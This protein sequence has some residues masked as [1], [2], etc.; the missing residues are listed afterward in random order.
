MLRENL[1]HRG[2]TLGV[3]RHEPYWQVN[4][5]ALLPS[6]VALPIGEDFARDFE[7]DAAIHKAKRRIDWFLE[8]QTLSQL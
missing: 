3:T 6:V 8:K 5:Y 1:E 7:K 4:V 2:Y